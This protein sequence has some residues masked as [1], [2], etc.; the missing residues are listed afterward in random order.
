[1]D[2]L[3]NYECRC[4]LGYSGRNC[5]QEIDECQSNPCVHNGTCENKMGHYRCKCPGGFKGTNCEE[6]MCPYSYCKKTFVPGGTCN[7]SCNTHACK[8][9][10]TVCSLGIK[11]WANCSAVTASGEFCYQVFK[12]GKCD[13]HCNKAECLFDGFDCNAPKDECSNDDYCKTRF[14]NAN[15]DHVCNNEACLKDGLD[16]DTGKPEPGEGTLILVLLVPPEVF[17]NGSRIFM[18]D[19]SAVLHTI[20]FIKRQGNEEMIYPVRLG[21]RKRRQV[22]RLRVVRAAEGTGTKVHVQLDERGCTGSACISTASEAARYLGALKSSNKLDLPYPLYRVEVEDT[23]S[24]PTTP[25]HSTGLSPLYIAMLCV[26]I[27]LLIVGVLAGAK[28]VYAKLWVPEGFPRHRPRRQPSTRRDPVGQE[29]SM[30]SI[31]KSSSEVD[32]EGAFADGESSRSDLTPPR[33]SKRVKLDNGEDSRKWTT[34][35][36]QAADVRN[37]AL[38]LT[39]PQEG[40]GE[41]GAPGVDVDARGPGGM[42]ALH[43]AACRGTYGDGSSLDDDKDSDDSGGAITSDLLSLGANYGSKTDLGETP[44]HLAARHSRADVA[45]RLLD[46]GADANARDRLN[47]TP[48]HLAIGA[49]AQGVFQILLRN[50]ATDLEARMDDG[51]TPL[52]LAARHDL[53]EQVRHLIKAGVK[54]NSADNQGKT[55]LHWAASVNSLEVTKELLRNGAKKDAQDEKGQTPLFLGCREG[56]VQTVRHLLVNY[57]N[58]KVADSMDMTPEDIAKQRHHHDIVELLTDWSL[59]CNSPKA[60]PAPTSPPEGQKSPM[61]SLASPLATSPPA[62]EIPNSSAAAMVQQ[63]HAARPK[64]TGSRTPGSRPRSSATGNNNNNNA[65]RKRKKARPDEEVQPAMS[66]VPTLSPPGS[67]HVVTSCAT[68]QQQQQAFSPNCVPI[69]NGLSP[70][71]SI[72]PGISP[73]DSTTLSP[74]QAPN[75]L[76]AQPPSPLEILSPE[77]L[78]GLE[79]AEML[80]PDYLAGLEGVEIDWDSIDLD[81][82]T[83]MSICGFSMNTSLGQATTMDHTVPT[84]S[85]CRYIPSA[86]P[87]RPL[88][89]QRLYSVHS[90][91]DLHCGGL[92]PPDSR[93]LVFNGRTCHSAQKA[94]PPLSQQAAF[95]AITNSNMYTHG[96]GGGLGSVLPFRKDYQNDDYSMHHQQLHHLPHQLVFPADEM[97]PAHTQLRLLNNY[98][99]SPQKYLSSFPTPSPD[100]PGDCSSSSSSSSC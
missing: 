60:V 52:I 74:L 76:D 84:T 92:Q 37:C 30:R 79:G 2:L 39:P 36:K 35:H 62:V 58:R 65:K 55:A 40:S 20:A 95:H 9:D 98:D 64:T 75:S 41:R 90:T 4:P 70:L 45:K 27:P 71:G 8:W 31:S 77:D 33:E 91:P 87:V 47:R 57:A 12:N 61:V 26:G 68:G 3:D 78:A 13:K 53:L 34:L 67:M 23:P 97:L 88:E 15:C 93:P 66:V 50:R 83:D 16:C 22:F 32:E 29:V 100:S 94:P 21:M 43:L 82:P 86:A 19:L 48:L 6:E 7:K 25:E 59:G 81:D 72:S 11:P 56:S 54:V 44:L 24:T 99:S 49:D 5:E 80:S 1:M 17:R 46:Y 96:G 63:F 42:T 10:G 51:T 28:R 73:A 18:R 38:A 69:T 14:E 89:G 85:D